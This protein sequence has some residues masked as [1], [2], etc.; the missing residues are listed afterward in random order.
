[1][2]KATEVA[3]IEREATEVRLSPVKLAQRAGV[4]ASTWYRNRKNPDTITLDTID[5]LESAIRAKRSE[6]ASA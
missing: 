1:M 5:K 4:N 6:M 3:R 2:D